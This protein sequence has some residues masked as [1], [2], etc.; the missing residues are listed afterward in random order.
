MKQLV[1]SCAR[2]QDYGWYSFEAIALR[3]ALNAPQ[4]QF[5]AALYPGVLYCA[6]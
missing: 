1:V 3:E 2:G 4:A 6:F 5:Q